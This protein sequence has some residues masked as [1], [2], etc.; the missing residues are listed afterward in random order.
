M[1]IAV[2]GGTGFVGSH[3]AK[4]LADDSHSVRVITHRR[5][6][7]GKLPGVEFVSGAIT[8]EES[9]VSAF[10]G[11]SAVV[12][13]VGIIVES[14]TSTHD[15]VVV[16][17]TANVVSACRRVGVSLLVFVSALGTSEKSQSR[18][19]KAKHAAEQCVK[20][21]GIPY[22]IFRPSVIYGK[23]DKFINLLVSMIRYMPVIPV[24]GNGKYLLQ[25]IFVEDF[26]QMV[27]RSIATPSTHDRTYNA[28]GPDTLSF[29]DLLALIKKTIGKRRV[30]MYLPISAMRVFASV[31]EKLLSTPPITRDQLLMLNEGNSGNI[32]E[33]VRI[34]GVHPR[35]MADVLPTYLR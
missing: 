15:T 28:A 13:A 19:H 4:Q 5:Q 1:K 11:C 26:A 14:G 9:L 32:E 7:P 8:N 12:H 2:L 23:G 6:S 29:R 20:N 18:Y 30:N 33:T 3:I 34:V 10:T 35:R 31:A 24:V 17:G 16:Q 22:V 25:P 27:S 21:S